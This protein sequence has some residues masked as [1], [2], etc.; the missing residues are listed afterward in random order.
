MDLPIKHGD[1]PVR[2]VS[3]GWFMLV[4]SLA[5]WIHRGHYLVDHFREAPAGCVS[6]PASTTWRFSPP[7]P[8]T[9]WLGLGFL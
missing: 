2:Y 8:G 3:F 1:F 9:R 7:W 6:T 4:Y 5:T